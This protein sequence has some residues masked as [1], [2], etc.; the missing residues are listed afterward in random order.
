MLLGNGIRQLIYS[1]HM[2]GSEISW[3][4]LAQQCAEFN[5]DD[6]IFDAAV[7]QAERIQGFEKHRKEIER[8]LQEI[9]QGTRFEGWVAL[10]QPAAPGE[11]H[12]KPIITR[13]LALPYRDRCTELVS[14][15][16]IYAS[17]K[18]GLHPEWREGASRKLAYDIQQ[19]MSCCRA[20]TGAA[21]QALF[22]YQRE[23]SVQVYPLW[24][25][26]HGNLS[27][28]EGMPLQQKLQYGLTA[29]EAVGDW[30]G[31]MLPGLREEL[32]SDDYDLGI[33]PDFL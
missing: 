27:K 14:D 15:A 26:E 5:S 10:Y 17:Q 3:E 30:L 28:L 25:S 7:I 21:L 2:P 16:L 4:Q 8:R 11:Q 29:E 33:D 12:I 1:V 31:P 18:L 19:P 23:F 22:S 9:T 6:P 20:K 24:H 13:E 32:G